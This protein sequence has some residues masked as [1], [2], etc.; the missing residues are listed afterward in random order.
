M[1][2][3]PSILIPAILLWLAAECLGQ[4]PP[5]PSTAGVPPAP[6][7]APPAV[8]TF[9][10]NDIAYTQNITN[11]VGGVTNVTNIRVIERDKLVERKVLVVKPKF[12]TNLTNEW[13]YTGSEFVVLLGTNDTCFYSADLEF[14]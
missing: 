8:P 2:Y 12:K 7:V 5:M 6:Q 9:N 11:V 13:A 1:K 10:P 3:L 14:K 4:L